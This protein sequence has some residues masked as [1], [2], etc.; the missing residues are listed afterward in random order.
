MRGHVGRRILIYIGS[1]KS[2]LVFGFLWTAAVAAAQPHPNVDCRNPR[3]VGDKMTCAGLPPPEP[4]PLAG[5]TTKRFRYRLAPKEPQLEFLAHLDIEPQTGDL[6]VRRIEIFDENAK[7][8]RETLEIEGES[9]LSEGIDFLQVR[10]VNFDG[11]SDLSV[12]VDAGATGNSSSLYWLYDP[13]TKHFVRAAM[14][15]ALPTVSPD[16][17]HKVLRTYWKGGHAGAI[18][19]RAEYRWHGHKLE[20]VRE[21]RQEVDPKNESGDI[22][23][24]VV[25]E[26]KGG[27]LKQTVRKKFRY[28][29]GG[30][31][32]LLK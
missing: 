22:Y 7:A 31:E 20:L 11:Y 32:V 5:P 28:A 13:K 4:V 3:T 12:I 21:E 18:Y 10:D 2:V 16:P 26:L 27:K 6:S 25:R 1:M 17:Q 8:P 30:E 23:L 14:L 15:D 24:R 9:F 19:T 29:P